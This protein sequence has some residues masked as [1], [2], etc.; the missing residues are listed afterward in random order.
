MGVSSAVA[1]QA[2]GNYPR[3]R[4]HHPSP[5]LS[6]SPRAL[7]RPESSALCRGGEDDEEG[8]VGLDEVVM[9]SPNIQEQEGHLAMLAVGLLTA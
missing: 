3:P 7:S 6:A 8:Q 2:Q 5:P 9:Y 1:S 4:L